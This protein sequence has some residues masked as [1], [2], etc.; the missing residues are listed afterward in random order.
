[1]FF[2]LRMFTC[3]LFTLPLIAAAQQHVQWASKVLK[4]SSE[5]T[6]TT[7]AAKQ[8]L[9]KPNCMPVGGASK[10]AWGVEANSDKSES[11]DPGY[12]RVGYATPMRIQQVSVAE[13]RGPGSVT[14]I[15]LFDTQGDEH[16]VYS[17]VAAKVDVKCRM[18]DVFFPVTSYE[19][20]AVEV[21][22]DPT[23][24]DWQQIDAI[25]ISDSHD[26]VTWQIHLA[27]DITYGAPAENLGPNV[28]SKYPDRIGAISADGRT[29]Y[30]TR[31][32]S[33]DNIG[34]VDDANDA[35]VS[36]RQQDGSWSVAQN[37]GRPINNNS[38]NSVCS[39]SPDGNTLLVSNS[40]DAR[41]EF[42]GDG[43]S[44]AHRTADGWSVPAKVKVKR[45]D[46]HADY[47]NFFMTPD[48]RAI[49]MSIAQ[50]DTYG[51]NDIYVSF[52]IDE[53]TWSQP[54][55]LGP[56]I[57]TVGNERAPFLAAD[58]VTMYFSTNGISGYGNNDIF[59]TRR[60]DST[61][62]HWSEPENLGPA[63]NTSKYEANY[64]VPASGEYAYFSSKANALGGTDIFRIALPKA[65]KP[66]PV[67][68]VSGHVFN[69]QTKAPLEG[70][71]RY[72]VL[73]GGKDAGVARSN[74]KNGAYQI[75]LPPGELYGFHAEAKG[76]YAV[77]ENLDTRDLAAFKEITK[78]LYLAPIQ[79]GQTIR[80]NNVFFES[81]KWELKP[82]SFVELNRLAK[83]LNE[84]SSIEIQLGGHTDNVGSDASNQT[85]SE[86]RIKS[87]LTY[88]V[89]QGVKEQR[90][91]AAGYG[92]TKPVATNDTDE[93]RALNRRV[94]FTIVKQ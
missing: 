50:D 74:P 39:V 23:I 79:V 63:I 11:K 48:S 12:I 18:F 71:I 76:Y 42:D 19:V 21:R 69:A 30:I 53:D 20:K 28:N 5:Y 17:A 66:N 45:Y 93:G 52:P 33:P 24:P 4:Y 1:M 43:I 55:N 9:G 91:A 51:A 32:S 38:L 47:V 26:S 7:C 75:A 59:V 34:G 58:G 83:V 22:I 31:D 15:I 92:R 14:K 36:T 85:L 62:T 25:G 60:I 89:S 80:I 29:M 88:L 57:N 56:D 3:A 84:N 27:K 13:N 61:W 49:L 77:S 73:P 35:Y 78:D 65:V 41:G 70:T 40:Y 86:N 67:V 94:E 64:Q 6:D 46:N 10:F 16:E 44:I 2:M 81:G 37:L 72:E 90:M 87:V 82:E 68:L 8:I 54:L